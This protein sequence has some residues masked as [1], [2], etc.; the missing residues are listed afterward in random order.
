MGTR[1]SAF[2]H[3]DTH[4]AYTGQLYQISSNHELNGILKAQLAN[5]LR[6]SGNYYIIAMN[7]L[8]CVKQNHPAITAY[9]I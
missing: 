6:C 8:L 1:P 7:S 4:T 5:N 9:I 2:L 3:S